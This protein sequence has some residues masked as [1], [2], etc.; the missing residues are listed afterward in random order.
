VL[1]L[2]PEAGDP[3]HLRLNCDV[4]DGAAVERAVERVAG[5]LG[6]LD[7][8][9]NNAGSAPR[10]TSPPTTTTSGT[11]SLTSTWSGWPG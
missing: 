11:G 1:D 10:A 4:T 5:D 3:R 6:R 2:D 9:V 8:V 7:V